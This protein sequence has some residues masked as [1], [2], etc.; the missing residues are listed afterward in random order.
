MQTSCKTGRMPLMLKKLATGLFLTA[1]LLPQASGTASEVPGLIEAYLR[2]QI[3]E[4]AERATITVNTPHLE[5]LTPCDQYQPFLPK[6]SKT[7]GKVHVG[8]RCLGPAHWSIFVG[9]RISVNGPYLSTARALAN[10]QTLSPQDLILK[11]GDLGQLPPGTLTDL[12]QAI[13]RTLKH[14]LP[15]DAPLRRDQL[16]APLVIQAGQAVRV[17][18]R[19]SGFTA[20]A[21]GR[22]IQN[23]SEGQV[24]QVRM[25]SGQ[26]V[27]GQANDRGEVEILR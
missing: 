7:L 14:P 8:L 15:A 6:G 1:C 5:K 17:I 18:Y 27:S 19:A 12:H 25:P 24:A 21:E 16:Q 20:S 22:A 10:G 13:G 26:I 2:Q 23:A 3:P 9:A 4:F 11:H